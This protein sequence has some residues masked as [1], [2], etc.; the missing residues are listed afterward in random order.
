MEIDGEPGNIRWRLTGF[1]GW[2]RTVDRDKSW[3]LLKD[4]CDLNSLP[5][6]VI[7]DFNE[8]LNS[9]EK[10]DGPMR[11][12]C[13]M[14]GFREALGY[15]DLLDL[16]FMGPAT[17]WWNSE[18]K[19]RLDR[20]VCTPSWCDICGHARVQHLP[21]SDSDHLPILLRANF[22]MIP[23]RPR[24]HRF[25]VEAH[26]LQH[27]ECDNVVKEA[28]MTDVTGSPCI[29]RKLSE[30]NEQS[31]M[32]TVEDV[33]MEAMN[34]TFAT[35]EP[36]VTREMNEQLCSSYSQDEIR[37]ALFQMYPTKSSGPDG[38]PPLFFQH[39]WDT[40]GEDVTVA[41]IANR[42]KLL[43][44]E[45]ISPYQSAFVPG[46]LIID[47]ILVANELAHF[48]HNKKGG[49]EGYMALKLN[50]SKAYNI[51]EWFFLRKVLER[52]GFAAVWIEMVMQC[53]SSVR[54][55]F[56]V[57][58]KPRGFVIPN[59]GLRQGDPLSP[60][61]FLL[62]VESFSTLLQRTQQLG[63]LLG[64][65]ICAKAPQVN[66]HLFADDSMLYANASL[67]D[68]YHI[69]DVIETYGRASGQLVNFEKSSIVL[70]NNVSEFM[71]EEIY[72]LLGMEVVTSHEKYLGLPTYVGRKKTATFQFI[73]ERLAK[74]VSGW[75][76]RTLSGAGRDIFIRVVAQSLPTY[77]MSVFKLIKNLCED[78]EQLCAKFWWGS[79]KEKRKIHWKHWKALC[80]PKEEGGLGFRSL[81]EFNSAMLAKQA[82]R[83]I[84]YPNSLVAR[85]FKT[86]YFPNDS[87]WIA[88]A[89]TSPSF[90]WRSIFSTRDLLLEGGYWQVG[91][92]TQVNVLTDA[93]ILGVPN[94]K[95][96]GNTVL[97]DHVENVSDLLH[98][99]CIWNE[100]L[101]RSVFNPHEAAAI[102]AIPLAPLSIVDRVVW[103][104]EKNGLFTT[105]TYRYTFS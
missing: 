16:G 8:I 9:G 60:Y 21:P 84:H 17:T 62:G 14:R 18:T 36:C 57:R 64:L 91:D 35:I 66:H 27:G 22:V 53:V 23:K 79:T 70:S 48:V 4:L 19:L 13:Q 102:L 82:W 92:G 32:F 81:E 103:R 2:P 89:H 100:S 12:K 65:E 94:F 87:F 76:D 43:L 68:C 72:S 46:R 56:L 90:S 33:D 34:S 99:L 45:V 105:K 75:Q 20:A 29:R 86:R 83:V 67:D 11:P 15:G 74:K 44:P 58:G 55:S 63:W 5:W 95:P 97:L 78:L 10:M 6:V 59:C 71:Q 7:G 26:W 88:T 104:F 50:L 30:D 1:Y 73:K 77:A 39:Y 51:M 31:R 37:S 24:L 25:K 42:L 101:I 85:L 3:Q 93:W 47:N 54:Y 38:M 80:N 28:W 41:V 69:Q 61:L 40:I 49:E 96:S 52:F 98:G